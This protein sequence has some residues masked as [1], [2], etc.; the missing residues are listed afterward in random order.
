MEE[1]TV[2]QR[3]REPLEARKGTGNNLS[4]QPQKAYSPALTALLFQ[5]VRDPSRASNL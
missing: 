3:I 5:L 1:G 2:H 4:L